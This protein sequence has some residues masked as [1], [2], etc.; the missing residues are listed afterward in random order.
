MYRKLEE[1]WCCR[2]GYNSLAPL[3]SLADLPDECPSASSLY[4][5]SATIPYDHG[6]E[7]ANIITLIGSYSSLCSR[8]TADSELLIEK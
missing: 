1:L 4:N 6:N 5:E 7:Y 2:V 3:S 8:S